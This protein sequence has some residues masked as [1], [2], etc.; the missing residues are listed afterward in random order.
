MEDQQDYIIPAQVAA[1]W[2]LLPGIGLRELA[3]TA[4]AAGAGVLVYL[5]ARALGLPVV[6]E[7][8]LAA[9]PPGAVVLASLPGPE[10]RNM[11]AI[12]ASVWRWW[13]SA[14]EYLYVPGGDI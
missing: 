6:V 1:R 4:V 7:G 12:A 5:V 3:L 2:E 11:W 8:F 14:H 10:G 9:L 13:H